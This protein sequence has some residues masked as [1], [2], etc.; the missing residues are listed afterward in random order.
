MSGEEAA[1]AGR[2]AE[3]ALA[4]YAAATGTGSFE[5]ALALS[6][7]ALGADTCFYYV[8]RLDDATR[9]DLHVA[10]AVSADRIDDYTHRWAPLNLRQRAWVEVPDGQVIDFDRVV[11][12]S[13]FVQSAAWR[14]FMR[15]HVPML[16]AL[17]LAV[18]VVPGLQA[19]LGLGRLPENGPFP[20]EA[21]ARLAALAPHLRRAARARMRLVDAQA[22]SPL[23]QDV[24]GL[25]ELAVARYDR[26]GRFLGANGPMRRLAAR[27]DGLALGPAGL[28][29]Q[30]PGDAAALA[31]AIRGAE[32]GVRLPLAR[33]SG[34]V[35]YLA[36]VIPI[37]PP[38]R[39]V[40]VVVSDPAAPVAVTEANLAELFGLTE[41]Q[42]ALAHAI[43]EGVPLN[44]HAA[45]AGI[46]LE[47]ARSRL[48]AVLARTGCRR[49]AE[50]AAL[51]ARLP[52]LRPLTP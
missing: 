5:Q 9:L 42:A 28:M 52:G 22:A 24:A 47:T 51:L 3:I 35:P 15:A 34:P 25:V 29:P 21:R 33:A 27:R 37:L 8:S 44:V 2:L 46:P 43:A 31:D 49:Q 38:K 50:L 39:E 4:F 13:E 45:C 12:A 48:K 10:G 18:T 17:G 41:G 7:A 36:D 30:R 26:E 32:S 14:G 20:N 1:A 11:P 6:R 19:R 16:H 40:L 23:P